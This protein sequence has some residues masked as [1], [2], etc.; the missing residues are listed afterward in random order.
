MQEPLPEQVENQKYVQ[1]HMYKTTDGTQVK[2]LILAKNCLF[3]P[4]S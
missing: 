2:W 3:S 1:V 4:R